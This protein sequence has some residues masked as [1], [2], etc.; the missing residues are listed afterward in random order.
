MAYGRS[1]PYGQAPMFHSG[2]DLRQMP[3]PHMGGFAPAPMVMPSFDPSLVTGSLVTGTMATI[4][5]KY[6][7][8][9]QD[10]GEPDMFVMP[11]ACKAF[12][13]VLPAPGTRLQ[14]QVVQDQKT[15]R[16]RA[17]EVSPLP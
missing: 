13:D 8:I 4:N 9:K 16:P 2:I 12:G 1:Q 3:P 6:G 7:F 17:E 5:G 15:G 10:S 14:F 11:A